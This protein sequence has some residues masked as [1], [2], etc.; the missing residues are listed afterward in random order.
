MKK[1]LQ[2]VF[3]LDFPL[4][5]HKRNN[6]EGTTFKVS[7]KSS[8]KFRCKIRRG[9]TPYNTRRQKGDYHALQKS[10]TSKNF[11]CLFLYSFKEQ[12]F[13]GIKTRI[14]VSESA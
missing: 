9:Q 13:P 1:L 4:D 2:S 5:T 12:F 14:E 8:G 6:R 11:F 3:L 10:Q 7:A